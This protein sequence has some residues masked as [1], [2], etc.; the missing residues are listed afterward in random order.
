MVNEFITKQPTDWF[1]LIVFL[2]VFTG[3]AVIR[4][5]NTS[6][7]PYLLGNGTL[8]NRAKENETVFI[9][10]D[11]KSSI[12]LNV[13]FALLIA[14]IIKKVFLISTLKALILMTVFCISQLLMWSLFQ[15]IFLNKTDSMSFTKK[16]LVLNETLCIITF[17]FLVLFH[18]LDQPIMVLIGFFLLAI[19][20]LWSRVSLFLSNQLSVFHIILYLCTLE[21][22][23]ALIL[24]KFI[25]KH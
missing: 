21:I 23:P 6:Y 19:S 18:Y 9:K 22:L 24:V 3:L 2:I 1:E 15:Y 16:R 13:C 14:I 25:I 4:Y 11:S 10:N 12:F 20:I 8:I 5:N 7:I 17:I